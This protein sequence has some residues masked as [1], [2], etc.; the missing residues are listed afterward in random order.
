M[1]HERGESLILGNSFVSNPADSPHPSKQWF[2]PASPN[3][4]LDIFPFWH[5]PFGFLPYCCS[6]QPIL[7]RTSTFIFV[8]LKGPF[9]KK[10]GF[11]TNPSCSRTQYAYMRTRESRPCKRPRDTSSLI[12]KNCLCFARKKFCL[13]RSWHGSFH[14]KELINKELQLAMNLLWWH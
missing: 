2:R 4:Q 5:R 11:K 12:N 8:L 3:S 13:Y 1:F 10:Y 6:C 14:L 9:T 7:I